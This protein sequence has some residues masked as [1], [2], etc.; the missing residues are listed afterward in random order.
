MQVGDVHV[1]V[2]VHLMLCRVTGMQ[3]YVMQSGVMYGVILLV[4][5]VIS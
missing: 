4:V 5:I 3:C 1:T 2:Y